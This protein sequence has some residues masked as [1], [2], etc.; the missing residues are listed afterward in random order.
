MPIGK[1]KAYNILRQLNKKPSAITGGFFIIYK[2]D[3]QY[4]LTL[5]H[6][7]HLFDVI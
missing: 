6:S 4:H 3:T 5:P 2:F 1:E 7:G